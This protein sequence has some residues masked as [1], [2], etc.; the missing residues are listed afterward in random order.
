MIELWTGGRSRL[1][2]L[3]L[4]QCER[5]QVEADTMASTT[6]VAAVPQYMDRQSTISPL[7][8]DN[9]LANAVP[10][11]RLVYA[12]AC[13]LADRGL[14]HEV[15]KLARAAYRGGRVELVQR[16]LGPYSFEYIA[17]VRR[18]PPAKL[19]QRMPG[20]QREVGA[21]YYHRVYRDDRQA[22]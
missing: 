18:R 19:P 14:A 10:G 15:P 3:R 21:A 16:R 2:R 11:E 9:W 4:S 6:H 20:D 7:R 17:I 5:Q 12:V 22:A 8:F 1:L 13:S